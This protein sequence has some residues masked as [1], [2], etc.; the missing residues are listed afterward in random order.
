MYMPLVM[1]GVIIY[2]R[3]VLKTEKIGEL[4]T[5]LSRQLKSRYAEVNPDN[6]MVYHMAEQLID[7]SLQ[8]FGYRA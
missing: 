1:G 7:R 8:K 4:L 3:A 6:E 2:D 5:E